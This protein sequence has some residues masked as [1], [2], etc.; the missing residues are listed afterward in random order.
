MTNM[1]LAVPAAGAGVGVYMGGGVVV[2]S[3]YERKML[4]L[5]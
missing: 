5:R 2:E 1:G 4:R 3:E